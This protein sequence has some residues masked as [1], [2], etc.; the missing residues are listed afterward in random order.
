MTL[1]R[2]RGLI[3]IYMVQ[4]AGFPGDGGK[5]LDAFKQAALEAFGAAGSKNN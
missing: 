4:H 1:D 5:S 2:K 3:L